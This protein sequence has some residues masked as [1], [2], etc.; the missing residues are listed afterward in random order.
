MSKQLDLTIV[1][2]IRSIVA[3][4]DFDVNYNINKHTENPT[5]FNKTIGGDKKREV[6]KIDITLIKNLE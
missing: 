6:I 1:D 2:A 5:K 4:S 3:E